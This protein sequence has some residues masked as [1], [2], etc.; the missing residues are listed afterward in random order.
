MTVFTLA[1]R[2]RHAATTKIAKQRPNDVREPRARTS[3]ASG[4]HLPEE[5]PRPLLLGKER[6]RTSELLALLRDAHGAPPLLS[7]RHEVQV[8]HLL[9]SI[10]RGGGQH[11]VDERMPLHEHCIPRRRK[12]PGGGSQPLL[13]HRCGRDPPLALHWVRAGG[14][15]CGSEGLHTCS[16]RG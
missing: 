10:F 9:L 3:R 16:R 4:R 5:L 6:G 14:S 1:P 7:S 8:L 11:R 13:M 12:T 15:G 2:H